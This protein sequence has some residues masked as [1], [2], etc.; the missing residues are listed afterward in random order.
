M[1]MRRDL[2]VVRMAWNQGV[3]G[4]VLDGDVVGMIRQIQIMVMGTDCDRMVV[5]SVGVCAGFVEDRISGGN[6]IPV[7]VL[8]A[9]ISKFCSIRNCMVMLCRII[10]WSVFRHDI[11]RRQD[12]RR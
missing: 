10:Y 1:G 5:R 3:V 7:I 8:S 9:P 11:F 6:N 4:M 12:N 2:H